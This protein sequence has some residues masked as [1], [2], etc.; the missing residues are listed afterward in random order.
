M[1]GWT[2]KSTLFSKANHRFT[3]YTGEKIECLIQNGNGS[4]FLIFLGK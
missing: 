4:D 3:W 2:R 1:L